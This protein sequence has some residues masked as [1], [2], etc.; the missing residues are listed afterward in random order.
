MTGFLMP[1]LLAPEEIGIDIPVMKY[2]PGA[3]TVVLVLVGLANGVLA[4]IAWLATTFTIYPD[5]IV[6]RSGILRRTERTLPMG[7]ITSVE[8]ERTL[9]DRVFGTGTLVL[10][11]PSEPA[12]VQLRAIHDIDR[13]KTSV[14][15]LVSRRYGG[16]RHSWDTTPW[17]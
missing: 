7:R 8:S 14:K 6:I 12:P 16:G 1:A 4:I 5:R 10:Y 13:V 3:L 15:D 17:H 11:D 9:I 2:V